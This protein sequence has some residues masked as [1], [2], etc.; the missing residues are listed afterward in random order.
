MKKINLT[1]LFL[2]P[3]TIYLI[4]NTGVASA[5][6]SSNNN[7]NL[8]IGD[9]NTSPQ[10]SEISPKNLPPV[11]QSIEIDRTTPGG[12]KS[13][14]QSAPLIF[15]ISSGVV[16]FGTLTPGNPV[17]RD[18]TLSVMSSSV[19]YQILSYQD[20]PLS[21]FENQIIADTTCDN[22]ACTELVAALWENELTYGLGFKCESKVDFLCA[23]APSGGVG[24]FSEE[25]SYKQFADAQRQE[26]P[27]NIIDGQKAE[28]P[29]EAQISL[30][31]NISGSQKT[32]RYSNTVSFILVPGY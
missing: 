1:S 16:D 7:Y 27:Q 13:I 18:A 9:I 15:S 22:G 28:K 17:I 26:T 5:Q 21:T 25:N 20:H 19:D 29:K 23:P 3:Y 12:I 24:G 8:E 31:L 10:G 2:I 14:I 11:E 30:K 32:G 4:L 6:T